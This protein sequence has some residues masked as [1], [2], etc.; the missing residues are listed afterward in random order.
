MQVGRWVG[1]ALYTALDTLSTPRGVIHVDGGAIVSE[2]L[3]VSPGLVW[4]V[5]NVVGE[6]GRSSHLIYECFPG[7]G[8]TE[9]SGEVRY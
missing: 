9:V 5:V 6:V 8:I 2:V 7:G 1:T 3:E 4:N